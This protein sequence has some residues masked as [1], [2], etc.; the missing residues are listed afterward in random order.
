MSE[1]N[2]VHDSWTAEGNPC[3]DRRTVVGEM[4]IAPQAPAQLELC[5]DLLLDTDSRELD[6]A[7]QAIIQKLKQQATEELERQRQVWEKEQAVLLAELVQ[8]RSLSHRQVERIHHLEQALD[9]SQACLNEMRLQMIDQQFLETQ[10]ASTEEIANIQQQAIVRLKR[11]LAEQQET[12]EH[13]KT[14]HQERDRNLQELLTMMETLAQTQQAELENLRNQI[15]RDRAEGQIYQQ[16]LEHQLAEYKSAF[17]T[18]QQRLLELETASLSARTRMAELEVQ[19]EQAQA[20]VKELTQTLSDR[21]ATLDQLE[22]ELKQARKHLEDQPT[23]IVDGPQSTHHTH[24]KKANSETER[25]LAI[26]QTKVEELETEIARQLTTQAML[27]HA[28][29][30]LEKERELQQTRIIALE[31]QT[32]EMQE[33]ILRQAQQAS[34]YETAVQH[35]KDR[36]VNNQ[37]RALQLKDLLEQA[38][39][40]LPVEIAELLAAM[41]TSTGGISEPASPAQLTSPSLAPSPKVDLPEFLMR[42]RSYKTKRS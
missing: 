1:P 35:W 3:S 31:R 9:Q 22:A 27:Q 20:Q 18:Q 33:Q 42:R 12:L 39:S 37:N 21:Q 32:H 30:E 40:N 28:C 25:E 2:I 13:Q 14:D 10:L 11:Q 15:A 19:L 26:A 4:A 7:A 23:L 41:Q 8:V 6:P 24:Q 34:E 17:G 36:Y 5:F 16:S 38:F 29:Q